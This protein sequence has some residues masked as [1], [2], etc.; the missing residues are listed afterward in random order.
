VTDLAGRAAIVTGAGSGIGRGI[1]IRLA[2]CG[3]AVLVAEINEESGR[4][5]MGLL[6]HPN[7][8]VF[9][10]DVSSPEGAKGSV[11]AALA[12]FGRLDI[13]VNNAGAQVVKL[14]TELDISE[15]EHMM[16]VNLRSVLLCSKY[17]I[18]YLA[19][20]G[21]AIINI[22]SVHARATTAEYAGYAASKSGILGLTRGLALQCA[23]MGVRVN[24][25]SPGT[26]D[27]TLLQ[28]YIE[29]AP[30]PAGLRR[31]LLSLQ[32]VG[33]FG[34]PRDIGSLVAFLAGD[35]ATFITGTEIVAD[36]GMTASLFR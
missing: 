6:P 1:A 30:D 34:N 28:R 21:G 11:D 4:E 13:L 18:P 32:P 27:T 17:A 25:V 8:S 26:I 3:A 36:G 14:S 20:Q 16:N 31:Q 29:S 7:A 33:R 15:W 9:A 23:P 19:R 22:A 5:T 2:E 35:D 10:A 12:A 24:T